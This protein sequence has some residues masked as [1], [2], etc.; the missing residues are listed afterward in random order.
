M[1]AVGLAHHAARVRCEIPIFG[2]GL[3]IHSLI[4]GC[5]LII[6]GMQAIG[7]GLCARA[8]GVYFISDQD[9]LFQ[10]P[11]RDGFDSSTGSCSRAS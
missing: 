11:A 6:L 10:P 9:Q 5:L 2:R 1:L 8:Y 7:F 4:I 3:Y